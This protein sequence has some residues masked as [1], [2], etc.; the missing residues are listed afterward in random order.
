[1]GH[2]H[3]TTESMPFQEKL[4]KLL[5]HWIKHNNDHAKTYLEWKEKA[6]SENLEKAGHLLEDASK[7]TAD[8]NVKFFEAIEMLKK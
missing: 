1:M 6:C 7:M 3:D 4:I 5:E 8:I 2:H